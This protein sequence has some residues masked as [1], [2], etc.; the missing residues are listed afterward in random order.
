MAYQC[1]PWHEGN[2]YDGI[3]LPGEPIKPL[4][5]WYHGNSMLLMML[6]T[7]PSHTISPDMVPKGSNEAPYGIPYLALFGPLSRRCTLKGV[8]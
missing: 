8:K 7:M 4:W 3:P 1:I 5:G 2:G 6:I